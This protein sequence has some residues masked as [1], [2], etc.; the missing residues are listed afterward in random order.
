MAEYKTD[1]RESRKRQFAETAEEEWEK[2]SENT[3]NNTE[4]EILTVNENF[5][6][7]ELKISGRHGVEA[8][9]QELEGLVAD[10]THEVIEAKAD[11]RIVKSEHLMKSIMIRKDKDIQ[12]LKDS[13]M[14]QQTRSMNKNI[15]LHNV[16]EQHDENCEDIFRNILMK[17]T[18]MDKRR[19]QA[20]SIEKAHR[21]GTSREDK[22][23]RPKVV[24]LLSRKDK[25]HII[26][27][28]HAKCRKMDESQVRLTNQVP[29][30]IV[31]RRAKNY[32]M[33]NDMKAKAPE[34]TEVKYRMQGDKLYINN[35]L[36]KPKVEKV[37]VADMFSLDM[38]DVGAAEDYPQGES[39]TLFDRGSSFS[40][41]VIMTANINEVRKA[42]KTTVASPARAK[43]THNILAYSI[44]NERSWEDDGEW[45]AGQFLTSWIKRK[46]LDNITIIVTRQYGGIHLGTK[47]YENIKEVCE[48][49]LKKVLEETKVD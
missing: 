27:G 11:N 29:F 33:V 12:M 35:Q 44:G 5:S 45:G 39:K 43:A 38:D 18:D 1:D 41:K 22:S 16:S 15:L 30:E 31:Q 20:L 25:E 23:A 47:R 14:D 37:T 3:D 8:R 7:L 26:Q 49:A 19:L 34:G 24:N 9:L 36:I 21:I 4:S 32:Q 40:A 28:W 13:I 42:Y 17:E 6:L 48:D 10:L 46:K 2:N